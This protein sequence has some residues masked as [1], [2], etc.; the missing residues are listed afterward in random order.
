M[1]RRDG[2]P[3]PED[4]EPQYTHYTT[5]WQHYAVT[6]DSPSNTFNLYRNGKSVASGKSPTPPFQGQNNRRIEIGKFAGSWCDARIYGA[7]LSMVLREQSHAAAGRLDKQD[8][9]GAMSDSVLVVW[10]QGS[11][12]Q[13]WCPTTLPQKVMRHMI[14]FYGSA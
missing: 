2:A 8:H 11:I 13:K 1:R 10:Q 9:A 4:A 5:G 7:V 14:F 12:R 6:Y 3:F